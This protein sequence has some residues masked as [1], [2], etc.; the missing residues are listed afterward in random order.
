MDTAREYIERNIKYLPEGKLVWVNNNKKS[1]I[2]K[3]CGCVNNRYR[4]VKL[5]TVRFAVHHVVWFIHK[6]VWP[7]KD[8][9][10]DHINKNKLD[11]RIENLREV[12]R[13]V[14]SLNNNAVNVSKN[15]YQY[16]VRIRGKHLGNY[17]TY[18][19]AVAA[20][21]QIKESILKEETRYEGELWEPPK[22]LLESS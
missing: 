14:N 2:G 11:N 16:R 1:L 18:E 5:G 6:G 12:T 13:S 9:D 4:Y 7:S 20:A 19:K 21:K 3:E 8:K 10:L 17:P 22:E 15:R